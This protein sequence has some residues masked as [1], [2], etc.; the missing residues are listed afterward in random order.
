MVDIPEVITCNL[1]KCLLLQKT[2][3]HNL[4]KIHISC[5]HTEVTAGWLFAGDFELELRGFHKVVSGRMDKL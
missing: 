4:H 5:A 3:V 1:A 2:P